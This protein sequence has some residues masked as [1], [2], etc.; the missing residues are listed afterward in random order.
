[1]AKIKLPPEVR[2][3]LIALAVLVVLVIGYYVWNKLTKVKSVADSNEVVDRVNKEIDLSQLTLTAQQSNS[4]A[5]ALEEAMSTWFGTD[6]Q[7]IYDT[8]AK[9]KTR[10][11]VLAVIGAFGVRKDQDLSGWLHSDLDNSEMKILNNLLLNK[12]IDYQF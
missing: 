8:F 6:E 11:D 4:M 5:T 7:T 1:M 12:G 3:I 2:W 9:C 10:S